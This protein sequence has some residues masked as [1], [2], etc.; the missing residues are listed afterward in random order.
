MTKVAVLSTWHRELINML[1]TGHN[2]RN[3]ASVTIGAMMLCSLSYKQSS[4]L[5]KMWANCICQFHYPH[6]INV[7]VIWRWLSILGWNLYVFSILYGG[8]CIWI[9]ANWVFKGLRN[10]RVSLAHFGMSS[11]S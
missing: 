7:L 1:D 10:I 8:K 4:R 2:N 6:C 3:N 5:K 11:F 9:N